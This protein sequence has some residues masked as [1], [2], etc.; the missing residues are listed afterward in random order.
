MFY[1]LISAV[2]ATT[3]LGE[4]LA[5]SAKIVNDSSL[6]CQVSM[7]DKDLQLIATVHQKTP[8][9]LILKA[10]DS[11]KQVITA[12]F[13]LPWKLYSCTDVLE[14][15]QIPF[16]EA[17]YSRFL[18]NSFHSL[19]QNSRQWGT[20]PIN[21]SSQCDDNYREFEWG[22]LF[23]APTVLRFVTPDA[24]VAYYSSYPVPCLKKL[25]EADIASLLRSINVFVELL[26]RSKCP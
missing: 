26:N 13:E 12:T 22:E 8:K 4:D 11:T 10:F 20:V 7:W 14:A 21:S 9:R 3:H 5:R 6:M 15:V 1:L 16:Y 25:N 23:V 18:S 17:G 19:Y 24:S 2:V